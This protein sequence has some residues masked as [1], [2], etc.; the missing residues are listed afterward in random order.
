MA[1][2]TFTTWKDLHTAMLDV[3]ADFFTSKM[4]VAEYSFEPSGGARRTFRYRTVAEFKD[5]L[6]FVKSMAENETIT[7]SAPVGRTYAKQGGGGRW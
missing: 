6:S 2:K 7:T 4:S 1:L 5:G 3:A